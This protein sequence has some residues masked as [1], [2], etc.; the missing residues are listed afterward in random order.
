CVPVA[1]GVSPLP[2][3]CRRCWW[4]V[5]VAGGVSPLPVVCPR[6]RWCVP[7]AG[8]VSPLLVVCPRGG[9]VSPLL[10]V[11]P[12]CWW[13]VPAAGGVSPLPKSLSVGTVFGRLVDGSFRGYADRREFVLDPET[14]VQ[15]ELEF[16][17]GV[18]SGWG[19]SQGKRSACD[20]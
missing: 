13:C 3:V 16:W 18:R 9:G 19:E 6:C 10:V 4:C 2:V 20:A 14:G 17:D 7:A 15:G 11:C 8:G 5:P 1:G 12:R